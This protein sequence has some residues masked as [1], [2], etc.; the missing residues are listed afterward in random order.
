MKLFTLFI[1]VFLSFFS[2]HSFAATK[3]SELSKFDCRDVYLAKQKLIISSM[4]WANKITTRTEEGGPYKKRILINCKR[5]KCEIVKS[6]KLPILK[7]DP[8]HPDANKRGIVA[9]P[10][11]DPSEE[12][13]VATMA[14]HQLK[15]LAQRKICHM[16]YLEAKNKKFSMIKYHN[17]KEGVVYDKFIFSPNG[18]LLTWETQMR[19]GEGSITSFQ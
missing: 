10:H 16:I 2:G 13:M 19:N 6:N 11:I 17:S 1:T 5:D 3:F 15:T 14:A 8:K 4:N 7:F 18:V 9:Y 12:L